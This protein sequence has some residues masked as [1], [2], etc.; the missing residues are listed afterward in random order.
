[1]DGN[2]FDQVTKLMANRRTRRGFA[3]LLS[4]GVLAVLP[5][6]A[7]AAARKRVDGL[8]CS[9]NADCESAF[10]AP[11]NALG[12]RLCVFDPCARVQGDD[13]EMFCSGAGFC[14]IDRGVGVYRD[15]APGKLCFETGPGAVV[16]DSRA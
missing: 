4:A 14:T 7:L 13:G 12:R 15:C 5:L 6:G 8:V 10:C 2:R 1:M 11:K 9:K 3:G 16:C